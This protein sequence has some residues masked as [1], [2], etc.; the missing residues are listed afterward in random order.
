MKVDLCGFEAGL[1]YIVSSKPSG[2]GWWK[3]EALGQDKAGSTWLR[4]PHKSLLA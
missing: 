2:E 3:G 4:T 1:L